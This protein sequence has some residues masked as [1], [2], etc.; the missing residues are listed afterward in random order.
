MT[1]FTYTLKPELDQAA[2]LGL[3]V[4]K[5]DETIEL[6]FRRLLPPDVA[7]HVS[8]VE[9]DA[10]VTPESLIKMKDRIT[11]A[12]AL[13]PDAS[14]FNSVGYACTSGTTIIGAD[15]VAARIK[16]GCTTQATT[17]PVDALVAKCARLHVSQL[18]ILSPYVASVSD[19]LRALLADY[20]IQT[21][22]IGSFNQ[23]DEASV[24]RIDQPS[25]INAATALC[26]AGNV[27]A[28]FISCTN[29]RALEAIKPIQQ[30]TGLPV[31]TSNTVLAWHMLHQAGVSGTDTIINPPAPPR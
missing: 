28:L 1:D 17:N 6:D 3:I 5:A 11:G 7:L 22:L 10:A 23:A 20:G 18:A 8:R 13:L 26:A 14:A 27:D 4:L 12:A 31:L 16:A 21:P 29:L 25:I 30:A 24:V 2:T 9:S 19:A 15:T